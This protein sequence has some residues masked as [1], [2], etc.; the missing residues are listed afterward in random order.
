LLSRTSRT[1]HVAE[2]EI[3]RPT[4]WLGWPFGGDI[5]V[6]SDQARPRH[7]SRGRV[8]HPGLDD[9]FKRIGRNRPHHGDDVPFRVALCCGVPFKSTVKR[10]SNDQGLDHHRDDQAVDL[11]FSVGLAGFEPAAP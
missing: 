5:N 7:C 3:S 11:R 9:V 4:A 1:R 8:D 6:L 2:H 10:R